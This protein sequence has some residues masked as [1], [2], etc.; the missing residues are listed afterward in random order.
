MRAAWP[1]QSRGLD[2][3]R[4]S[5]SSGHK[6]PMLA[7]PTGSG[8]TGLASMIV[9]GA[10]RKSKRVIFC[11]PAISLINQTV[12][13]FREQG[14][15]EIGVIQAQHPMT[16]WQQPIQIASVQT[17]ERR[18]VLPEA[19]IVVIDEAH[20][21]FKFYGRWMA[22]SGWQNV[23]FIGLSATP[24]AKGLG[25][26]YDDL[27]VVTTTSELIDNG[28]LAPFRVFAPS[29][30]DLT[31]VGTVAGDYHEGQLADAM[32]RPQLVA[33]AV[34]NWLRHGE[35]RP[36]LCFAVDRAHAKSL[37]QQFEASGVR[38]GYV[39]MNTPIEERDLVG[40]QLRKGALQ[41]V[42]NVGVLTTGI[43]WDV[44][45]IVLCR[46]TKS[47]M[48][49]VQIIG[50]GLRLAEGKLDCLVFDHSDTHER[51]GFVTDIHHAKLDMGAQRQ[52]QP[53]P[54]RPKTV[55]CSKCYYLQ[56][57]KFPQCLSCGFKPQRQNKVDV[58]DGE[59]FELGAKHSLKNALSHA[60]EQRWFS[61]L[62]WIVKSKNYKPGWAAA[63][64]KDKFGCWPHGLDDTQ[65]QPQQDVLNWV[66]STHIRYAKR[67][68]A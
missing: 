26:H 9:E 36:T 6:R 54:E 11:V 23:P 21:W 17:L 47:E 3:L 56:P 18:P 41:V 53:R 64:F 8:K 51:L 68:A 39:D 65:V 50:R 67:R 4:Q 5:I 24:W 30:P 33:D 25:K 63:K 29:H 37:Q 49:F 58:E 46:P 61:S 43:D 27:L 44:R 52:A 48:L 14:I 60:D 28:F 16:D 38:A 2:L 31:S 13:A 20:R 22:K 12:A 1:H 66:R 45:C 32:N 34:E 40:Q 55:E 62:V 19:D 59:L 10:L 35:N 42:C 57:S 15:T 7:S